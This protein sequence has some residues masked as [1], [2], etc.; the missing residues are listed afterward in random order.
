MPIHVRP[1]ASA[2]SV[3]G[4]FD[5]ALVVRVVEPA[6]SGRATEAALRAVAASLAVPR[7][8][9]TLLSGPKSRR[10][11]VEIDIPAADAPRVAAA[12]HDLRDGG[13][14]G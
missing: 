14:G 4:A 10:K 7:R 9:V 11:L 12:L 1:H 2:P 8:C 3:G 6:A 13:A 5:G